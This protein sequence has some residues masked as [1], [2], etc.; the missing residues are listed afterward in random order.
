MNPR[1]IGIIWDERFS[2]V[3]FGSDHPVHGERYRQTFELLKKLGVL[4]ENAMVLEAEPA[5]EE[6][7]LLIHSSTYINNI[8]KMSETG[9]G[10]L[11]KDTPA[12]RGMHEYACICVG[13]T[14][15]GAKKSVEQ[16]HPFVSLAGGYHHA[17]PDKGGGFNIYN[18]IAIT[19]K[20]FLK[21]E[22]FERIAIVD[23]DAHHGNAVQTIFYQDPHVLKIS[24]HE[25]GTS[26]YPGTG[27]ITEIGEK[28]G[29]GFCINFPFEPGTASSDVELEWA[30]RKIIPKA[31]RNFAPDLIIWQAGVDGHIDD[32]LSNL[33]FTTRG[34]QEITQLFVKIITEL[35]K[36]R[37]IVVA[38]GGY[39]GACSYWSY[40]SIIAALAGKR[41]YIPEEIDQNRY[42]SPNSIPRPYVFEQL[43]YLEK[44][45]PLLQ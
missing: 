42:A 35:T 9:I 36:G 33:R 45:I 19:A 8:K 14:L 44:H 37:I 27:F 10:E 11:S 23:T 39:G 13:G 12:F 1:K 34:Y 4:K 18:D 40:A 21:N 28:E 29:K 16:I 32:P 38:G 20:W 6:D 5:T 41:I 2:N 15:L 7:L 17:F 43:R 30:F 22:I 31:L 3:N 24:F 26:L 25:T